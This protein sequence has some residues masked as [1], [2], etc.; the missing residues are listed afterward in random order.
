MIRGLG[1]KPTNKDV[2]GV[3]GNPKKEEMN[4]KTCTFDDFLGYVKGS[5]K[6]IPPNALKNPYF[7]FIN[8]FFTKLTTLKSPLPKLSKKEPSKI[9]LKVFEFSI[10][11][12]MEPLWVLRRVFIVF[13]Y[14]LWIAGI[15][16][17]RGTDIDLIQII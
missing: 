14:W 5:G 6:R 9:L 3:L 10:K 13:S 4:T 17:I 2:A 15:G 16:L 12:E 8:S 11:K 1:F 7:T